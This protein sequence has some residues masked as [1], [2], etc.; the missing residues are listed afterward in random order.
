MSAEVDT[1]AVYRRIVKASKRG[2]GLRLCRAE[3]CAIVRDDAVTQAIASADQ[4]EADEK[5][6]PDA[7]R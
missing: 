3:V 4:H 2:T 5:E 1:V 7:W 6:H